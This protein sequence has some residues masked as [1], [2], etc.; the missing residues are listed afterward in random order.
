M[1]YSRLHLVTRRTSHLPFVAMGEEMKFFLRLIFLVSTSIHCLLACSIN[2]DATQQASTLSDARIYVDGQ[3]GMVDS[4]P[5]RPAKDMKKNQGSQDQGLV[6]TDG[7]LDSSRNG[8]PLKADS[9]MNEPLDGSSIGDTISAGDMS[10]EDASSDVSMDGSMDGSMSP[11]P[12]RQPSD[13]PDDRE[14][15]GGRCQQLTCPVCP[16][17]QNCFQGCCQV[18]E[19]PAGSCGSPQQLMVNAP[20]GQLNSLF[21]GA[22]DEVTTSCG[23]PSVRDVFAVHTPDETGIYCVHAEGARANYTLF[24]LLNCCTEQDRT[25]SAELACVSTEGGRIV[26]IERILHAGVS[27]RIGL[28]ALWNNIDIT[29][30]R[31]PCP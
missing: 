5:Q 6:K 4:H 13:C 31:G 24:I 28:E 27:Y 21:F 3:L 25:A 16:I 22:E 15:I 1:V 11:P 9:S 30:S 12:C 14:C 26:E 17:R 18:D 19:G 2:I 10:A 7:N 29:L 20:L 8:P 23:R